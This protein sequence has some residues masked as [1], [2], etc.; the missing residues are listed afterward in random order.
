MMKMKKLTKKMM[1]KMMTLALWML[2]SLCT[3]GVSNSSTAQ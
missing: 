3:D 1:R 2:S